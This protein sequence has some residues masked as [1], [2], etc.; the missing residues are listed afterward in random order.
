M[1][2]FITKKKKVVVKFKI[3]D[4]EEKDASFTL[5]NIN[6]AELDKKY[7]MKEVKKSLEDNLIEDVFETKFVDEKKRKVTKKSDVS[8][9]QTE[10]ESLGI[11]DAKPK[12]Y[13]T[14]VCN[15]VKLKSYVCFKTGELTNDLKC[16]W[17]RHST[18]LEFQPL[19]V[20]LKYSNG[21]F[22]TEG[23]V[24]SF[25]CMFAYIHENNN[26]ILYKDSEG[27]GYLLYKSI[28]K[29]FPYKMSINRAPTWKLLKEYGGSLTIEEFRKM[30]NTVS[31]LT[32]NIEYNTQQLNKLIRPSK[33]VYLE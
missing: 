29:E 17:C 1:S 21:I 9:L 24:C 10:L 30:F 28:F 2:K 15:N 18:P 23:V 25:N 32:Q 12:G 13:E 19:G 33:L 6:Q 5:K 16:W 27:L 8:K 20:P 4:I 31:K 22:D 7:N 3:D 14:M 11:S 26:N